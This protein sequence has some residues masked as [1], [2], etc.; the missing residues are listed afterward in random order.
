MKRIIAGVLG[1]MLLGTAAGAAEQPAEPYQPQPLSLI[2]ILY[3]GM[4]ADG[5]SR[6]LQWYLGTEDIAFEAG[7]AS[8]SA[9]TSQAHSVVLLRLA[10]GADV[11]AAKSKLAES[12]RC[13]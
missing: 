6:G 2:H 3:S 9:I 13:V 4:G 7:L 5:M 10:D 1:A 11:D 12:V 8:E